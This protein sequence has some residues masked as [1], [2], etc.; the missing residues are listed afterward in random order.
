MKL[1]N[2]KGFT[3][4]EI[5]MAVGI[6]TIVLAG[7]FAVYIAG[8]KSWHV[9]TLELDTSLEASQALEKMV[10]GVGL[11]YGLRVAEKDNVVITNSNT[12]W[13]L[14][15]RVPDGI[16]NCFQYDKNDGTIKHAASPLSGQWL[17]IA[18]GVTGSSAVK[19]GDGVELS[20]SYAEQR[21]NFSASN[22]MTTFVAFRN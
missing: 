7:A 11:Q 6:S 5:M 3:L 16:T 20:V 12:G 14:T 15:Y 13:T 19:K 22:R 18:K 4:V 21:G 9:T 10:Y 1:H 2:K 8:Q 17:T